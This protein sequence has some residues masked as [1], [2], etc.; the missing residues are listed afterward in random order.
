MDLDL[1]PLERELCRIPEVTAARVVTDQGGEVAEVHILATA[2]KQPKQVVRDVQSVAMATYGID[3]DRRV[4]SVVQ[5]ED[6]NGTGA[7]RATPLSAVANDPAAEPDR[8]VPKAPAGEA[9]APADPEPASQPRIL[10]EGV[11]YARSGYRCSVEVAL[12]L[13]DQRAMGTAEGPAAAAS[14]ARLVAVATLSALRHLQ[15]AAARADVESA[16]VMTVGERR[17]ATAS[18]VVVVPPDEELLVGSAVVRGAGDYDAMARAVLDATN[19]R[20]LKLS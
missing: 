4:I 1:T 13:G 6:R 16:T 2:V 15:P 7:T 9:A 8:T 17:V 19:R 3:V 12:R 18:L 14:S 10:V 5:L 11:A 20:L